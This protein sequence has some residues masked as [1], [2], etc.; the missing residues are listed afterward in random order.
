MLTRPTGWAYSEL[1]NLVEICNTEEEMAQVILGF[2]SQKMDG[3]NLA[4]KEL[5]DMGFSY[6]NWRAEHSKLFSS[7]SSS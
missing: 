3:I 6:D 1:R 7:F 5:N 4:R 2:K